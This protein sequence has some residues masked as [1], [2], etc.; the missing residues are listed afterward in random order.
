M[1]GHRT[2]TALLYASIPLVHTSWTHPPTWLMITQDLINAVKQLSI[3]LCSLIHSETASEFTRSLL[4]IFLISCRWVGTFQDIT[5]RQ[6]EIC[7]LPFQGGSK[8]NI[9]RVP[10]PHLS[11]RP[12]LSLSQTATARGKLFLLKQTPLLITVTA[13][14]PP[15]S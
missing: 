10:R 11:L 6:R 13:S 4:T 7:F 8:W 15:L 5:N 3:L 14:G 12:P 1:F 2:T 9:S